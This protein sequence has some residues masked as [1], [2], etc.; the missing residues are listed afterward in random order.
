MLKVQSTMQECIGQG[1]S[2]K[3]VLSA[4]DA[5][6]YLKPLSPQAKPQVLRRWYKNWGLK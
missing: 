1:K 6:P 2:E 5:I 4:A 3:E